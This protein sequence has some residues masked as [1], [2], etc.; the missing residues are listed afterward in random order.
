MQRFGKFF[1]YAAILLVL[2]VG[3]CGVDVPLD[4]GGNDAVDPTTSPPPAG[5]VWV[6]IPLPANSARTLTGTNNSTWIDYYEVFFVTRESTSPFKPTFETMGTARPGE[7]L[8]VSLYPS[9]TYS[10]LLLAGHYRTRT[11][12]ASAY[13]GSITITPNTVNTIDLTLKYVE[14]DPTTD[15]EFTGYYAGNTTSYTP[16]GGTLYQLP[17]AEEITISGGSGVYAQGDR[18]VISTGST[19]T[20]L[21]GVV[22]VEEVSGSTITKVSIENPGRFAYGAVVTSAASSYVTGSGGTGAAFTFTP[23]AV[24]FFDSTIPSA[25]VRW[26]SFLT[27]TAG[28]LTVKLSTN[29]IMP[30]I[31]AGNSTGTDKFSLVKAELWLKPLTDGFDPITEILTTVQD[32]ATASLSSGNLTLEYALDVSPIRPDTSK[33]GYFYNLLQYRAF[34]LDKGSTW[35]IKSGLDVNTFDTGATSSGSRV[36]VKIGNPQES[37]EEMLIFIK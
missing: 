35:T 33:Y 4:T 15:F 6:K 25:E 22:R 18:L 27:R 31:S 29:N 36:L 30:L 9:K 17:A 37:P 23:V 11:L 2:A 3:G 8:A 10:A 14:S 13:E 19:T 32:M 24:K 7:I 1:V 12:L 16:A 20:D 21:P 5:K 26:M 28:N 34:N